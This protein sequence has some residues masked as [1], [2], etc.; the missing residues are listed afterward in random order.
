MFMNYKRGHKL[1]LFM[2]LHSIINERSFVNH[3]QEFSKISVNY[4][5]I[6]I[7][8]FI[9]VNFSSTMN[10]T[11]YQL[12]NTKFIFTGRTRVRLGGSGYA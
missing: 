7:V 9:M 10:K 5:D 4:T 3:K 11:H 8:F 1:T 6:D 12:V 2:V